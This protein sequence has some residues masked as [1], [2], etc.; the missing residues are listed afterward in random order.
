MSQDT[1]S[2]YSAKHAAGNRPDPNIAD[3][4]NLR[5]K[6]GKLS[7]TAAFAIAEEIGTSA[8]KVGETV[9]LL[10]FRLEKCQLGLFGYTPEKK[11]VK[12]AG[13][14]NSL[15]TKLIRASLA[16]DCLPCKIAWEIADRLSVAR[17]DVSGACEALEV[18]I[19]P[20]QLGA[21]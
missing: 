10:E 5:A 18:K 2:N 15:M 11:I 4:V 17:M 3:A 20:C 14:E 6:D 8:A 21:F 9:D 7:C 16:D 12:P 13:T 19:K 1:N